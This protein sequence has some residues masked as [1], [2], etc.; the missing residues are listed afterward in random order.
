MK[1]KYDVL[2]LEEAINFLDT[3]D[4]KVRTK[5]IYNIKKSKIVKSKELF[6]KLDED[7]WEFRTLYSKTYYRLFAFWDKDTDKLVVITHGLIKKSK[8][9]PKSDITHAKMLMKNY[10]KLKERK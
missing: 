2:F 5:I 8:K 9:T 10:K 4:S 3:L 1:N 6:K 7:I